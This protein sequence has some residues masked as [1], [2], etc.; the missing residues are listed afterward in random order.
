MP[1]KKKEAKESKDKKPKEKEKD[2]HAHDESH[3]EEIKPPDA[4]ADFEA[5]VMFNK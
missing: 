2:K 5:G 1:P 4:S 3:K